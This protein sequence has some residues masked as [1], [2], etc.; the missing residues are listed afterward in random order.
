MIHFDSHRL[1]DEATVH[2][3]S[4]SISGFMLLHML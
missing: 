3:L 4:M 2:M 1:F